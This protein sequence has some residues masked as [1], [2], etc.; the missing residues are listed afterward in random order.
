MIPTTVKSKYLQGTNNNWDMRRHYKEQDQFTLDL[1]AK[2]FYSVVL[3]AVYLQCDYLMPEIL[4]QWPEW[5]IKNTRFL[6]TLSDK[7]LSTSKQSH[8]CYKSI[9]FTALICAWITRSIHLTW[10]TLVERLCEVSEIVLLFW[11]W[12]GSSAWNSQMKAV[13]NN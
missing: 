13:G 9:P 12:Y 10:S 4:R 2:L 6:S 8:F 3:V 5:Q 7:M 1:S 11:Y